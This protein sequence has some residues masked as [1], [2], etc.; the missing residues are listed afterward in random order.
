MFSPG[1]IADC[2]EHEKTSKPAEPDPCCLWYRNVMG[3][4]SKIQKKK[5]K[6]HILRKC[7]DISIHQVYIIFGETEQRGVV[8]FWS[9]VGVL[10]W[11]WGEK[12]YYWLLNSKCFPVILYCI[13]ELRWMVPVFKG[14]CP[15]FCTLTVYTCNRVIFW[16][17]CMF[18]KW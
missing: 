5:R 18:S 6:F 10:N 14:L 17:C 15:L 7:N 1:H 2:I 12:L 3:M 4:A 9:G 11:V 8:R 13:M 16:G